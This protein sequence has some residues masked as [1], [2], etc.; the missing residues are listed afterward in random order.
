M[1]K[2]MLVQRIFAEYKKAFFDTIASRY[3]LRL[4]HSDNKSGICQISTDYSVKVRYKKHG[5]KET[6]VTLK[7]NGFMLKFKPDVLVHEFAL[8][9]RSM[10]LTLILAKLM[11]IKIILWS[12]GYDR[13]VGFHPKKSLSDKIRILLM[14]F[15]DAVLLYSKSDRELLS[16]SINPQKLFVAQNTVNT[17]HYL[18]IKDKLKIEGRDSV[19]KRL[20]FKHKFNLIFIGRMI[21]LK[22][23]EF[24]IEIFNNIHKQLND[25]LGIHFVGDGEMIPE[26]RKI[27]AE[28]GFTDNLFFHGAVY[29]DV[30]SG[31]LLFAS[32]LMVMPENLGLAINHAFCFEC[33]VVSFRSTPAGPFH[34]PEEEYL[35]DGETGLFVSPVECKAM[36]ER[37]LSYLKD[38]NLQ[39]IFK[40]NINNMVENVCSL[41]NMSAGFDECINFVINKGLRK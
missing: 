23:P 34:G 16:G 38:E 24:L 40:K 14:K 13:K 29:D 3:D 37:I 15:A 21:K 6:N 9:I 7:L 28:S 22:K 33:P 39:E 4:V 31:E 10:P 32:D 8:G 30:K 25:D 11:G 18:A 26:L 5:D 35:A 41:S 36:S 1:I 19:K 12:H 17:P 2:I 20:G 27:A